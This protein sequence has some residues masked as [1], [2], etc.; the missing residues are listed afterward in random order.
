MQEALDEA[1]RIESQSYRSKSDIA[2]SV[3]ELDTEDEEDNETD[4]K[5]QKKN[6][7]NKDKDKSHVRFAS[8]S[9]ATDMDQCIK[10]LEE[11]MS[12]WNKEEEKEKVDDVCA[13]C[14]GTLVATMSQ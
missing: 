11:Q 4:N 1:I 5:R 9:R 7:N 3:T 6:R 2:C 13:W 14:Y 10:K 8:P 12:R